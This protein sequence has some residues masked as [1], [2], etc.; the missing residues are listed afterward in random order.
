MMTTDARCRDHRCDE[1]NIYRMVGNCSNCR[2]QDVLVLLTSG[3]EAGTVECPICKTRNVRPT[4]LAT[5]DEVPVW[6]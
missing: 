1:K 6:G 5:E 3:H 4:R 2:A